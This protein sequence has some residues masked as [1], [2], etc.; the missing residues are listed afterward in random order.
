MPQ[1]QSTTMRQYTSLA[2]CTLVVNWTLTLLAF[3]SVIS[4]FSHRLLGR[5]TRV[6]ADDILILVSFL[7]GTILVSLSTWTIL[8]EGQGEHQQK[9][10]ASQLERAA[11]V[12]LAQKRSSTL[13]ELF[14]LTAL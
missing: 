4:I 7:V 1:K 13:Q 14:P 5:S 12:S 11:K 3:I 9:V 2:I 8:E 6:G 10:S